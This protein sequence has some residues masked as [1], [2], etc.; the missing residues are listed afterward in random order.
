MRLPKRNG[1]GDG[2]KGA[3]GSWIGSTSFTVIAACALA[4]LVT[5]TV[6]NLSLDVRLES[7]SWSKLHMGEQQWQQ[8][9][10]PPPPLFKAQ[11]H[12]PKARLAHAPVP[13][14]V[15]HPFRETHHGLYKLEVPDESDRCKRS[16][17]CDGDYSC[18]EDKLG[19]VTKAADRKAHVRKAGQWS[20][21]GYRWAVRESRIATCLM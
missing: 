16:N 3:V 12:A 8:H 19:C 13:A 14:P 1:S 4:A 6:L 2:G 5:F 20:W 21:E 18:G 9:L 7:A 15:D 10:A 17:I 11:R